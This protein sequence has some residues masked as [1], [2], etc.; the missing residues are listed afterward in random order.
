MLR[1]TVMKPLSFYCDII[2]FKLYRYRYQSIAWGCTGAKL[3]ARYPNLLERDKPVSHAVSRYVKLDGSY[4]NCVAWMDLY[5]I[6]DLL[7]LHIR[8]ETKVYIAQRDG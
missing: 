5:W 8:E 2:T 3:K 6:P 4:S 7:N 1:F